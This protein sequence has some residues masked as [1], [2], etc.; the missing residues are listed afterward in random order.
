MGATHQE[1]LYLYLMLLIRKRR[2]MYRTTPLILTHKK[3]KTTF[4][5]ADAVL[6]E[7]QASSL[8]IKGKLTFEKLTVYEKLS[9]TG[10][11]NGTHLRCRVCQVQGNL[12]VNNLKAETISVVGA[13]QGEAVFCDYL[14][15]K[16]LRS[17]LTQSIVRN[18]V[19]KPIPCEI[20]VGADLV[21]P[22]QENWKPNPIFSTPAPLA[23]RK[24]LNPPSILKPSAPNQDLG[25]EAAS[26][27][28]QIIFLKA[29]TVVQDITFEGGNGI[30]YVDLTSKVEG[31]VKGGRIFA[32][33]SLA[34]KTWLPHH[35]SLK[36]TKQVEI[37]SP[38]YSQSCVTPK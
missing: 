28:L 9:V 27:A 35:T 17:V 20:P 34:A 7:V 10:E 36:N 24:M 4:V 6:E 8:W 25:I 1:A 3:I 2:P 37:P 14:Y 5:E 13:M 11:L 15:I 30:V 16:T 31:N 38:L 26:K 22:L 32:V 19:I 12:T 29:D 21:Q 18:L 33:H 23:L